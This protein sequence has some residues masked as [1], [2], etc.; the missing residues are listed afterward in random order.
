MTTRFAPSPTGMSGLHLGSLRTML[1]SW[2]VARQGQGQFRFRIEDTDRIRSLK[3]TEEK[4]M[5]GMEWLG[6]D[7]DGPV[8]RQ[9]DNSER[10]T[11]IINKMLEYGLAYYCNCSVDYLKHMKAHQI[12]TKARIGYNSRCREDNHDTGT[13]RLNVKAVCK[14]MGITRVEVQDDILGNHRYD[15]R[16][17]LDVV[18]VRADGTPTYILA[19]TVD[20]TWNGIDYITR[21]ADL[22][23]QTAT[24]VVIRM[25]ILHVLG[26]PQAPIRYAHLPLI[27]DIKKSKLSKR[28]P[29][30]KGLM[31]Y[32][33][34]GYMPN[35]VM[36]FALSLGNAS[37]PIDHAMSFDDILQSFDITKSRASNTAYQDHTLLFVNRLHIRAT[38]SAV[39]GAM[40]QDLYGT[41]ADAKLIDLFKYRVSTLRQL[42]D[43]L[44]AV[45]RAVIDYPDEVQLLRQENFS[46]TVCQ[47]FRRSILHDL[48]TAPLEDVYGL[49]V[50]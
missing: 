5:N 22:F 23:P 20:D 3:E 1:T 27:T 45:L 36:Q 41:T 30:T 25:A 47:K 7:Y 17:V 32:K 40:L 43:H 38:D 14:T 6:I 2:L 44:Q 21:G 39:L 37:I 13:L 26:K 33:A 11:T 35:A 10:Y 4:I 12:R 28:D 29:N 24:Q 46:A 16:D 50:V 34:E 49:I 18:L 48:Q 9:S 8:E 19:N 42:N 15:Y 31:D